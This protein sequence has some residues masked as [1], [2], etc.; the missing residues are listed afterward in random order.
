MFYREIKNINMGG[1]QFL[2]DSVI[3]FVIVAWPTFGRRKEGK[4]TEHHG[5]ISTCIAV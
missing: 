2:S 1:K 5:N 4:G 3:D